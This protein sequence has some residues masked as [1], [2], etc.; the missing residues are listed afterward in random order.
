M[1]TY[2]IGLPIIP[3]VDLL[4]IANA[5][6]IFRWLQVFWKDAKVEAPLIGKS[7]D[8]VV[9]GNGA[10]L[11]PDMTFADVVKQDLQFDLI[12]VPGGGNE[13]VDAAVVDSDL[14]DFVTHQAKKAAWVTSVCTGAFILAK[15]KVLDG[16]QCTTHWQF[17]K[18]LQQEYPAVKLVNG[19]PRMVVDGNVVTGGGLSS[20]IDESLWLTGQVAGES[21]GKQIELLIQYNPKPP[22]NVGDPSIADYATYAA[23]GGS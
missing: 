10:K 16:R 23:L 1:K 22:W 11:S 21:V 17:Q 19:W 7:C 3:K 12:F 20:S 6:E 14:I 13:Y 4:D 9:T 15:A 18:R 2:R 8:P 5:C